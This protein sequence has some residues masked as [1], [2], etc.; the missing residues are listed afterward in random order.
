MIPHLFFIFLTV[1]VLG[2]IAAIVNMA[3]IA[4]SMTKGSFLNHDAGRFGGNIL[5][6]FICG[7][8]YV[9]GSLGALITGIMWIVTYCKGT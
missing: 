8:F 4:R 2:F 7:F 3:L 6:H 5:A 9:M 1:A